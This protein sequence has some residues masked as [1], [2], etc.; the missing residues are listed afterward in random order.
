MSQ[1]FTLITGPILRLT[2]ETLLIRTITLLVL[3]HLQYLWQ[4]SKQVM[5]TSGSVS[6]SQKKT[7]FMYDLIIKSAPSS[8]KAS[9]DPQNVT[10]DIGNI[11]RD[12]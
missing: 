12:M 5:Y 9:L 10:R 3:Y 1:S 2:N 11:G 7:V 4:D 6:S 8:G